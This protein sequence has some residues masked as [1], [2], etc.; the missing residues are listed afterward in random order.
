MSVIEGLIVQVIN[1]AAGSF[2]KDVDSSKLSAS[3]WSGE[4]FSFLAL[5]VP[6]QHNTHTRTNWPRMNY[7]LSVLTDPTLSFMLGSVHLDRLE[8]KENAFV[9]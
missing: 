6:P 3:L 4:F 2:V 7:R 5:C 1:R 9:S 8:L